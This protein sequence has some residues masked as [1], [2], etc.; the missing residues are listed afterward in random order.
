MT[1][2]TYALPV[3]RHPAAIVSWTKEEM[4]AANV[5]T[6]KLP[7]MHGDFHSKSNVQRL[8]TSQ[9]EGGQGLVSVQVTIQDETQNIQQCISK[10]APKDKLLGGMSQVTADRD[11]WPNRGGAVA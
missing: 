2:N 3:I 7:T 8:Y 5:K 10:M 11:Q 6:R 9:K 1:I 4:A